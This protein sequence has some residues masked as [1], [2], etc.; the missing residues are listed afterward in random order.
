MAIH[1]VK[2]IE[3]AGAKTVVMSCANCYRTFFS[4]YP[5]L[6]GELPFKVVH[7][8]EI[9]PDL[10]KS[11]KIKLKSKT[12]ARVTLHD[13]CH[14]GKQHIGRNHDLYNQTRDVIKYLP[15]VDFI[16]MR[17]IGR[18]SACCGGGNSVTST[19]TPDFTDYH[20]S[21]RC[22]EAKEAADILLTPCVRCV[23]NLSRAE[24]K[25][26]IGVEVKSL[27]EAVAEMA[28]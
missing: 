26:G 15:K 14:F 2:A 20:S 23:E 16:E 7:A 10:M 17:N 8:V 28:E 12:K 13:P 19:V 9:L 24:R 4:D 25:H 6:V 1:N 22:R 3:K 27:I 18:W 21:L 11:G 5:A